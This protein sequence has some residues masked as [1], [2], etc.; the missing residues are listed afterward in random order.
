MKKIWPIIYLILVPFALVSG[1]CEL[2]PEETA[3]TNT[4]WIFI[5]TTFVS[6]ALFSVGAVAYGFRY[7][8]KDMMRRPSWDRHPIGWWTDTLQPLRFTMVYT[9]LMALG[10]LFALPN[11]DDKGRM[12]FFF[13]IAV[14]AGVFVGEKLVYAIYRKRMGPNKQSGPLPRLRPDRADR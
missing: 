8:N 5:V 10:A 4:D 7:S 11:A 9:A 13:L 14:T 6:L 3:G 12:V 1:Y 2:S